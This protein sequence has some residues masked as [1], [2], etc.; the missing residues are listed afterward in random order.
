[1]ATGNSMQLTE[2]EKARISEAVRGAEVHTNAE[3][4]PMLVARSGLYRDAQ[5]RAGLA[6][7]L[8]VLTGLLMGEGFWV[9]WTWQSLPAAW[10]LIATLLAY[11]IGSW[12]GTF[13]PA[14]RA[15]TSTDRLRRKV[16]L[17]AERA[18]V[19]H[20]LAQTRRRTGVLL[21]VSLL[22][23]HVFVLPDQGI[24]GL[25][26]GQWNE[27]VKAVVTKLKHNDVAGGFCAGIEKCGELLAHACPASPGDN[28]DEL[29]NRVVQEP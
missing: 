20:R 28:P 15:I 9:S 29:S 10:L 23:R 25:A 4:V 17:R 6:L 5:H 27:V 3:I 7:A 14:I 21:L 18:F 24:T 12:I 13:P 22:E 26:P 16:Q 1:M 19:Q 8:V 11:A 2:Q